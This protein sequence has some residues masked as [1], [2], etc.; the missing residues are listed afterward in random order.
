MLVLYATLKWAPQDD[1]ISLGRTLNSPTDFGTTV[2]SAAGFWKVHFVIATS[3]LIRVWY[4][5]WQKMAGS[6]LTNFDTC[7]KMEAV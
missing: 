6:W 5:K 2:L 4:V 1:Y 3:T 7:C